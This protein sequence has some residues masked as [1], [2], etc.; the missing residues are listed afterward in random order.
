MTREDV[1]R[2]LEL[3]P[4]W[5]LRAQPVAA[6][7]AVKVP[8]EKVPAAK[9]PAEK[10]PTEKVPTEKVPT[11]KVLA[12]KVTAEK[13]TAEKVPAQAHEIV[14]QIT[15]ISALE[16]PAISQNIAL[17][18]YEITLSQDKHWAFL[19]MPADRMAIGFDIGAS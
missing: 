11:E 12:E 14:A 6:A 7:L 4:V 1:L 2:E 9:V 8:A 16:K 5:K 18:Q 15:A 10:V 17:E 3:L 13:V 19:G